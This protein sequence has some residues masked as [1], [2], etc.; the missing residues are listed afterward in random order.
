MRRGELWWAG[1]G[2]PSGSQSVL[3]RP[4]LILQADSFN[5]SAIQT[6]VVVPLTSN[7]KLAAAP[8]NLRC[9]TRD[10]GLPKPSVVNVSQIAVIDRRRLRERIGSLPPAILKQIEDGVRLLLD[11]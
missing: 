9:A 11:L 3:R 7:L 6:V 1:L 2:E 8:G 5:T 10:T 4:V